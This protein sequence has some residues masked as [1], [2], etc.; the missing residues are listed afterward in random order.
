MITNKISMR[1]VILVNIGL[2]ALIALAGCAG[3]KAAKKGG[4]GKVATPREKQDIER[5][6]ENI[7]EVPEDAQIPANLLEPK[8]VEDAQDIVRSDNLALFAK[9]DKVFAAHLE[10]KPDDLK[11]LT[12]H[13]QLYLAWADSARLTHKT[14]DGSVDKLGRRHNK[15][16]EELEDAD[17]LGAEREEAEAE[18]EELGWLIPLAEKALAELEAVAEEKLAVGKEKTLAILEA[19][20]DT[21]EGFRL[22]ADYYR[23]AEEW[24]RYE[25]FM[26]ELEA[27]NPDSNGLLFLKGVYAFQEDKDFAEAERALSQAVENDAKFTKAQYYLA[28]SYLNRR[29]FEQADEAMA[30]TLEISPGHPFAHAVRAFISRYKQH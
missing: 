17:M 1:R 22:G 26:R 2:A 23:Q 11:N 21:Y 10:K 29:Q 13:T 27:R 20:P 16:T 7:F 5:L 9:A 4:G 8:T 24:D 19:H 6:F 14:L 18:L 30:R 28:L 3:T 12:W 15:L 25:H